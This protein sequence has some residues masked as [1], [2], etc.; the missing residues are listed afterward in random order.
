MAFRCELLHTTDEQVV[1]RK[2]PK[3]QRRKEYQDFIRLID[4]GSLPLL[5][6]TVS[7]VILEESNDRSDSGKNT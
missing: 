1:K 2:I 3:R 6:D 5:D 4:L 7:E